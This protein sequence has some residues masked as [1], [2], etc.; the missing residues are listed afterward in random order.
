MAVMGCR[1]VAINISHASTD[2][3]YLNSSLRELGQLYVF[4]TTDGVLTELA[5]LE[6]TNQNRGATFARQVARDVKGVDVSA[7]VDVATSARVKTEIQRNSFIELENAFDASYTQT[8]SDLAAE[9]N[10]REATGEDVGFT[11]FLDEAVKPGSTLR[12]LLVYSTIRADVARVGYANVTDVG[13]G[14][15]VPISGAGDVDVEVKGLSE[16]SFQGSEVPVLVDYH[17]IQASLSDAGFYRFRV[18]R[19]FTQDALSDVLKGRVQPEG[20]PLP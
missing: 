4:D 17:V 1:P 16:E 18:D 15:K 12:Y 8:F 11:W 7:N 10:R 20:E 9:I 3:G 5:V 13:G 19:A 6:L 2:K 14:L